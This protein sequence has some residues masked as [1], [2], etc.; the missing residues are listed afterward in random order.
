L[1]SEEKP[2]TTKE[3]LECIGLGFV[4][5][6]TYTVLLIV[7]FDW[8]EEDE[9]NLQ[10]IPKAH[11]Q[12]QPFE[13]ELQ[14]IRNPEDCTRKVI[15]GASAYIPFTV[16]IFY[17]TTSDRKWDVISKGQTFPVAQQTA[18]VATFFTQ[19]L[20]QY[21]LYLEINY[22]QAKERQVYIE[23]V[24]QGNVVWNHQEKFNDVQFCMNVHINTSTPPSF[25]TREELIGDLLTNVDQ[26]P[27][28]IK[29]FNVNT[30]TWNNSIGYMWT[31]LAGVFVLSVLTLIS[32]RV[33]SRGFNSRMKDVDES[34]NLV[35]QSALEMDKMNENF[36]KSS[37]QIIKNQNIIIKNIHRILEETEI[38][39]EPEEE[40]RISKLKHKIIP[41]KKEIDKI[42]E[43]IIPKE[44]EIED[45]VK[46]TL[47]FPS[48]ESKEESEKLLEVIKEIKDD[49]PTGGF[50]IA[51]EE[52]V[53]PQT[54]LPKE[55][56]KKDEI[57]KIEAKP[58]KFKEILRG[59]DFKEK[60]FKTGEFDKYTYNELNNMYGWIVHYKKRKIMSKEWEDIPEE[61][62]TKQDIAEKVIYYAIFTKMEKKMKNGT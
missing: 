27:T 11:A 3:V 32:A 19:E 23:I 61:M 47:E 16:K 33:S 50:I 17:D 31:L 13:L 1:T 36:T 30:I 34:V 60:L 56:P 15:Q 20:D 12:I 49:E 59:I 42:D 5:A 38:D 2:L 57:P 18:Q 14:Q 21:Q 52:K 22:A 53:S 48:K 24:S 51:E 7:V 28:M 39:V 4:I 44:D 41:E 29:S 40:S 8:M 43:E 6:I 45:D 46:E 9:L 37:T 10:I 54:P 25:P 62:R 55:E 58:T 26:I 35:N